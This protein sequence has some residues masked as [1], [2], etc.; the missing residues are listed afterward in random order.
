MFTSMFSRK[1]LFSVPATGPR[2]REQ[3]ASLLVGEQLEH[4][5]AMAVV[6]SLTGPTAPVP[7]GQQAVFTLALSEASRVPQRVT[8][9]TTP[10]SAT[11]GVDYFAPTRQT[12]LFAPGQTKQTF[13]IATLRDAGGDKVEGRETFTVKATPDDRKLAAR[14]QGVT[15]VD[16]A[17]ATPISKFQI[18]VNYLSTAQGVVPVAVRDA[19]QWAAQRWSQIIV[20]DLPDVRLPDG[21]VIDDIVINVQM[22]L[23]GGEVNAPGGAY[24]NAGP[25]AFRGDSAGLPYE[26]A[27]G[28]DPFDA[29]TPQLRGLLL[30]EFGH[31]LGIGTL[32]SS[33]SLTRTPTP[34]NPT[35]IGTNAVRE[36][37]R[38]FGTTGTSVPL[39]NVGSAGSYSSH[40]RE[41]VLDTEVMTPNIEAPGVAMPLSTITVGAMQDLGYSVNYAMADAYKKPAASLSGQS[42][43]GP[44]PAIGADSLNQA[45]AKAFAAMADGTTV[46]AKPR[47]GYRRPAAA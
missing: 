1:S 3:V 31:A 24:A 4:R 42:V 16:T 11:Y 7:E 15:I 38:I 34:D 6:L 44:T 35:Y 29:T 2:R 30:H 37:N 43:N 23:L 41:S 18:T 5:H 26:A 40:W 22:G 45:A 28:I 32:W 20:G 19:C 39:A 17:G 25:T 47:S 21:K 9:T 13:S 33:K 12:F 8:I 14:S 46:S 10:G 27:A 36:F